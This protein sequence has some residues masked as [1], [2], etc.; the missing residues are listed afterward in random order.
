MS[1]NFLKKSFDTLAESM[2]G[3]EDDNA[4]IH[5]D[6]A[7]HV[8]D[9]LVKS[10]GKE[11]IVPGKECKVRF[12]DKSVIHFVELLNAANIRVKKISLPFH[13]ISG[14]SHFFVILILFLTLIFYY[15]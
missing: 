15:Y 12:N 5:P 4:L 13:N 2:R 6:I 10:E 8:M 7:Q 9:S 14:N 11:I 3:S 1:S